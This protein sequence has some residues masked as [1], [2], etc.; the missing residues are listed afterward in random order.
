M[1][2]LK[3]KNEDNNIYYTY[4]NPYTLKL[5]ETDFKI[6]TLNDD[7]PQI[8]EDTPKVLKIFLGNACNLSCQYCVYRNQAP[9]EKVNIDYFINLVET[10]FDI[11]QL[12]R[13]EY[14]GGEPLLYWKEILML[15]EVF[16]TQVKY[17]ETNGLLLN[18][19][20]V[21]QIL[22]LGKFEI[23]LSHDGPSQHIRGQDPL[24]ENYY[25]IF[26]LYDHLKHDFMVNVVITKSCLSPKKIMDYFFLRFG[27]DIRMH[28]MDPVIP[29]NMEALRLA[30][31]IKNLSSYFLRDLKKYEHTFDNVLRLQFFYDFFKMAFCS[32]SFIY[33][34]RKIN[35]FFRR[36]ES[37]TV[38]LEGD[39]YLGPEYAHNPINKIDH[40]SRFTKLNVINI[41]IV[42]SRCKMCPVIAF[43]HGITD[44][45]VNLDGGRENCR[46]KFEKFIATLTF[47]IYKYTGLKVLKYDG[48]FFMNPRRDFDFL[49]KK[50]EELIANKI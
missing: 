34:S 37:V 40:L 17:L 28:N 49:I 26:E 44:R 32:E 42:R 3:V 21:D 6:M 10:N 4:F 1:I 38:T 36:L 20:M 19:Y 47:F 31:E 8:R 2:K 7:E 30:K 14:H 5:S 9:K 24:V 22:K 48:D 23:N 50:A 46:L 16:P 13:I 27:E 41:P 29:T 33:N 11:K 25:S 45:V 12:E 18:D 43:C 15:N 39:I 35:D